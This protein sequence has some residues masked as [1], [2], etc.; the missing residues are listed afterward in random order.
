MEY[1]FDH[2]EMLLNNL[3][4]SNREILSKYCEIIEPY[5]Y[6]IINGI[7]HY[8]MKNNQLMDFYNVIKNSLLFSNSNINTV[9][10]CLCSILTKLLV[11][12]GKNKQQNVYIYY[13]IFYFYLFIYLIVTL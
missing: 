10:I 3:Q 8:S 2:Y 4:N 7:Y 1:V 9:M 11:Q 5:S 12:I 6:S 13:S